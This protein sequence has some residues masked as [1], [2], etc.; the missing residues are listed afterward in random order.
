[1]DAPLHPFDLLLRTESRLRM[2]RAGGVAG[3]SQQWSGLS[4]RMG[5]YW[6]VA[7]REEVREVV[8][9]PPVTRIPNAR[10]WLQG[11]ANVRGELLALVDLAPLA[12][13]PPSRPGRAQR[14]LVVDTERGAFA[15]L[16]DEVGGQRQF[17][18]TE[19]R[20]ELIRTAGLPAGLRPHLLGAF[21]RDAQ[22]FF[23]LSLLK[24]MS[25][26]LKA[27]VA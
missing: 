16:V 15:L 9:P 10:L 17:V 21:V 27:G 24:I 7:P 26:E 19:Q 11:L 2:L 1:M 5:S 6:M 22:S 4:F 23:A 20:H 25:A 14:A 8:P 3:A 12:G 18:P 13:L